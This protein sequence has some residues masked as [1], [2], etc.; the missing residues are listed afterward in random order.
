MS[1]VPIELIVAAFNEEKAADEALSELKAAK[2]EHLIGI[3]AAA[4]IRRDAKGKLH[5]REVGE[6]SPG[7]GMAGGAVLG[8][9]LGIITG[10]VGLVLG[11]VG[12]LVGRIIGKRHDVGFP[13]R[14]L[15][16]VGESLKPGSSA[17]AAVIEHKWVE[18][19]EEE[20][21][22]LGADVLTAAIAADVA[23]Q[24]EANRDVFYSALADEGV[25]QTERVAV[26]DDRIE[27]SSTVTTEEGVEH[28]EVVATEDAVEGRHVVAT[29]EGVAAEAVSI[30]ED[31]VGVGVAAVT[32][33]AAVL[34]SVVASVEPGEEE[35]GEDAETDTKESAEAS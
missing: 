28:A 31:T 1:E 12:A 20:L 14:R 26:G 2:K 18:Q 15:Q 4:V 30:T 35:N 22:E 17:I 5:I 34:G 10:G 23:E 6:L 24:L 11:A 8:A 7:R 13:N 27:M 9:A 32:E 21:D 16:Q 25:L 19:L 3:Q 33:G 29:A